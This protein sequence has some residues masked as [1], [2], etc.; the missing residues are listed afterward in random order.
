MEILV[1]DNLESA[2]KSDK[3]LTQVPEQKRN[4]DQAMVTMVEQA[5]SKEFQCSKCKMKMVSYAQAQ[6][7]SADEPMT[8]FCECTNCG[9][10]WKFS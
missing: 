3:L 7:G 10:R 8:T 1:L 4:G 5:I 2:I 9:N 6:T